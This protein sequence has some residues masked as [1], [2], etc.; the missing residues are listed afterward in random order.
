MVSLTLM[1]SANGIDASYLAT[2][3]RILWR[4]QNQQLVN[5]PLE[6]VYMTEKA[7]WLPFDENFFQQDG[8][9]AYNSH[10]FLYLSDYQ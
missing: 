6:A 1:S 8:L 7:R 5:Q 9:A 3:Q 4:Q 2:N 10:D